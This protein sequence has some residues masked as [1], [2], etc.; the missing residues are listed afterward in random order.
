MDSVLYDD[1]VDLQGKL[2]Q[3]QARMK[4]Q[5]AWGLYARSQRF[6]YF[7][8]GYLSVYEEDHRSDP[9][10]QMSMLAH[11]D[12]RRHDYTGDAA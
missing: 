4:A 11:S 9:Q 7:L 3:L 10:V 6:Q 12:G 2:R 8:T 5:E 1:L